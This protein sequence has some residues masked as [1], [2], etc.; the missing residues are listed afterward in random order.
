[1]IDKTQVFNDQ[2]EVKQREL[3][4]WTAKINAKQAEVD[5]ATSERVALEK[6]AASALAAVNSAAEALQTLQDSY[7]AKTKDQQEL[8]KGQLNQARSVEE[9]KT[10]LQVRLYF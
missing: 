2:I 8:K 6:K 4:P 7:A 5:V 3:Q 9:N 1:M 10:K